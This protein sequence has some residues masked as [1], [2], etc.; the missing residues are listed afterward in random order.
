ME[1]YIYGT[2][3][4]FCGV[5]LL[6]YL[7]LFITKLYYR[8]EHL[9][10][11]RY[12]KCF[13]KRMDCILEGLLGKCSHFQEDLAFMKRY[14]NKRLIQEIF[15]EKILDRIDASGHPPFPQLSRLCE[16]LGFV[17][18]EINKLRSRDS[19][20][21]ALACRNLGEF[22]STQAIA[23]LLQS[24]KSY[25]S[26]IV[27]HGLLALA[28][29]GDESAF[30]MAFE[31]SDKVLLLTE[32]SLIEIADSFEGDKRFVC[33]TMIKNPNDCLASVFI[34]SAGNTKD[35]ALSS[36]LAP[37]LKDTHKEKRIAAV[38]ALGTMEDGRYAAE[39]IGLLTDTE[40]EVRAVAAKALG[41][42]KDHL[43]LNPLK[44][45]LSDRQWHVRFNA[46]SAILAIPGGLKTAA[47]VFLGNDQFAKDIM[48]SAIENLG[49]D[50]ALNSYE[51]SSDTDKRRSA[52]IIHNYMTKAKG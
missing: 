32:R 41:S 22:R 13:S 50:E 51:A 19:F 23:P 5:I 11:V 33:K 48:M 12:L 31:E 38:K 20:R 44:K 10:K 26:D 6:L 25:S 7:Y 17:A 30:I 29:I 35:L 37:F 8:L 36:T 3:I 1:R 45:A 24:L 14:M 46:A 49:F 52:K 2:I 15:I 4:F 21:V 34:K 43:A 16:A 9:R 27:Y 40:W 47:R 18:R 42:I 28:K 39:I